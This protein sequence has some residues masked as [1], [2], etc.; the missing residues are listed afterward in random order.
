[1]DSGKHYVSFLS[2]KD[3]LRPMLVESPISIF[4]RP[5]TVKIALPE[6]PSLGRTTSEPHGLHSRP[7]I[8]NSMAP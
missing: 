3:S 8:Q 4:E 7:N 5:K 6:E 1:M 2:E